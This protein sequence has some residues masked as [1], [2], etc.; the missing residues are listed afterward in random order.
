MNYSG[1][2]DRLI[3]RARDRILVGYCERHHVLPRCLG[4]GNEST[5]LVNLTPEEHYVA[6]QLLVKLHPNSIGLTRAAAVM[7]KHGSGNKA[8]GWLR[9]RLSKLIRG[10]PHSPE[11]RANLAAFLRKKNIANTGKPLSAEHKRKLSISGRGKTRPPRTNEWRQKQSLAQTGKKQS[12]ETRA[13]VSASLLGN[14]RNLG[15]KAS[16]ETRALLSSLLVV[17]NA[18]MTPEQHRLIKLK[19]WATRRAKEVSS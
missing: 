5:N 12:P 2:Y 3:A 4:G 13:R 14:K 7:S 8:Y 1:H 6:H 11:H 9:R 19:M 18:S 17:R 16:S 15:K 10:R